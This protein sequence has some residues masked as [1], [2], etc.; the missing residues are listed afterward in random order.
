MNMMRYHWLA[1]VV[2][3][4]TLLA[5]GGESFS[6]PAPAEQTD[7]A[8]QARGPIHE[9]YARPYDAAPQPGPGVPK[10]PPE[11][12]SEEPP[13]QKPEGDNVRWV[14]GYWA[15]DTD[16]NDYVWVSGFWRVMPSD[17]KWVPGYWRNTD[18]G[19][20]WVPGFWAPA[21]QEQVPLLEPPPAPLDVGPST[22]PPD[23]NHIYVPGCWVW[24]T[25]RYIWRPGYWRPCRPGWVWSPAHYCWTPG[26]YVYVDGFWDRCLEDRGLLFAPVAFTRPL[27]EEPGWCYRPQYAVGINTPFFAALFVGPSYGHYYFGDYYDTRCARLGYRPWY[28]YGAH[29]HDPLY[30]YYGWRHRHDR[31]WHQGLERTYVAR[32]DGREPRPPRTLVEQAALARA[33][34]RSPAAAPIVA[35]LNDLRDSRVRLAAIGAAQRAEQQAAAQQVRDVARER[36]Q[37]ERPSA[38]GRP[39]ALPGSRSGPPAVPE[40]VTRPGAPP[41]TPLPASGPRTRPAARPSDLPVIET[42]RSRPVQTPGLPPKP[43]ATPAPGNPPTRPAARPQTPPVIETP[44]SR[45]V[46]TPALPPTGSNANRPPTVKPQPAVPSSSPAP[47]PTQPPPAARPAQPPPRPAPPPTIVTPPSRPAPPPAARPTPQPSRPS[48][49]PAARPAPQPSRP[50]QPPPAARPAQPP[51]RPAPPP[52]IV[53][54]PSRPAPPAAR[55][56]PQPSR[57]SAPPA[58]RP[59]PSR[60]SPPPAARGG[61]NRGGRGGNDDGRRKK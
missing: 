51:P 33:P 23:D 9:A 6:D 52:T 17:R 44:R 37:R 25:E 31:D 32:R 26:G 35:P 8:V 2:A 55:P 58:A 41:A 13:E 46:Q 59:A 40:I 57:P 43:A 5:L 29:Y 14:P 16:K 15:W 18:D 1:P 19:W 22:L 49:P 20:Q 54:P 61:G 4:L 30:S 34:A 12:I 60:P 10:P 11:P 36:A 42:P 7:V 38:K 56:T 39:I 50:A 47:Q 45:P 3:A 48:A 27:W 28:H 24:R 53:T 21:G